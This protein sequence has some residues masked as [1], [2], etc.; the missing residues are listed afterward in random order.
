VLSGLK[1]RRSPYGAFELGNDSVEHRSGECHYFDV[2][3]LRAALG[4]AIV[5]LVLL[6]KRSVAE[7]GAHVGA[8]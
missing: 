2:F 1:A 6:M 4:V 7:K 5:F 3:W 8:E